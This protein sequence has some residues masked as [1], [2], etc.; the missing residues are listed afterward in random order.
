MSST[1]TDVNEKMRSI[2]VDWLVD[3]HLKFKLR[4]ETLFLTINLLDRY[5]E[6]ISVP[7]QK[8][9]LVGVASMLIACKYEEIYAPETKDFVFVTDRAYTKPEIHE[10]EGK[11][12]GALDFNLTSNSSLKFLDRYSKVND[13]SEKTYNL[14]RFLIELSLVDYKMLKYSPS[15]IAASS[16]YLSNKILKKNQAWNDLM[17]KNTNF[18]ESELRICAKDLFILIQN[19]N[20]ENNNGKGNTLTAVKRK[21]SDS[22]FNAVSK[23]RFEQS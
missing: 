13:S 14:A 10:M 8:L 20:K 6:K 19:S 17:E 16:L 18:N 4:P 2:L 3:V 9:Q 22:K 21:F 12:L 15:H 7:R 5:L 23:I 1:Q 11:I